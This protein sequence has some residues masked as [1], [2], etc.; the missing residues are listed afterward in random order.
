MYIYIYGVI[1]TGNMETYGVNCSR[2]NTNQ[3]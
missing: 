2:N 3:I 1:Y